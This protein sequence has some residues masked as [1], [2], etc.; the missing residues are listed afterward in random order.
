[1]GLPTVDGSTNV[2]VSDIDTNKVL[3]VANAPYPYWKVLLW[4][5][6]RTAIWS[7][8]SVVSAS[9]L[10]LNASLSNWNVYLFGIAAGFLAG[11]CNTFF[12]VMRDYFS[13]GEMNSPIEKL[14]I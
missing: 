6:A 9:G 7:S 1:M 3:E 14:P 12:K 4:R 11:F 2:P 5:F 10:T 13:Q 8:L